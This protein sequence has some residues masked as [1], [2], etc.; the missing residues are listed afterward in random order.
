MTA[1]GGSAHV[2]PSQLV[3]PYAGIKS[4]A[5]GGVAVSYAQGVADPDGELIDS[6]YLDGGLTGQF[7]NGTGMSGTPLLTRTDPVVNFIWGGAAPAAGVAQVYVSQP[8]AAGEPPRNLRGFRK[9]Q[10]NP[11][12]TTHV[13]VT[14]DARSFQTWTGGV[15]QTT[16]GTHMIVVGSSSRDIRLTGT[17]VLAA[18]AT[19]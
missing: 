5:G 7:Y 13:A 18:G 17:T 6:Q 4:R 11:G 3:T 12:Q 2:S 19:S 9:V 8:A 15:W 10:L 14:L 16:A 1:G